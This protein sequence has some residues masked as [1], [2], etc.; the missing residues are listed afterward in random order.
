MPTLTALIE[1]VQ[2]LSTGGLICLVSVVALAV[3]WK[4]L[5]VVSRRKDQ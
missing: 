5:D 2:D 3:A 1:N 4:A